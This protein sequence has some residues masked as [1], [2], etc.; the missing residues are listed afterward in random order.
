MRDRLEI[1]LRRNGS[2][3][4]PFSALKRNQFASGY[5]FT[6]NEDTVDI[7]RRY[8]TDE[9]LVEAHTSL[10]EV[11]NQLLSLF[12][13]YLGY[14][15]HQDLSDCLYKEPD[16]PGVLRIMRYLDS[17]P[18]GASNGELLPDHTDIGLI[19]LMPHSSAETL[20]ILSKDFDWIDVEKGQSSDTLVAIVGEQLAY[21][22]NY[23]LRAVRHRVMPSS[24]LNTTRYSMPFL[25][26]APA[27][28]QIIQNGTDKMRIA[29]HVLNHIFEMPKPIQRRMKRAKHLYRSYLALSSGFEVSTNLVS[30]SIALPLIDLSK[31][32]RWPIFFF[33]DHS[34]PSL[35]ELE[36]FRTHLSSCGPISSARSLASSLNGP[37][38]FIRIEER[39]WQVDDW[40]ESVLAFEGRSKGRNWIFFLIPLHLASTPNHA[41]EIAPVASF[42][43]LAYSV[44]S[45][46]VIT[47]RQPLEAVFDLNQYRLY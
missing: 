21:L 19:T 5:D 34:T 41:A 26:R 2:Q 16:T 15:A 27:D 46:I 18:E 44:R 12:C 29:K 1:R 43:D 38:A 14:S 30:V 8:Y 24:H 36:A 6:V 11:G 37:S 42:T 33:Y 17:P 35:T 9:N 25:M 39:G 7:I 32:F 40:P 23:K 22:S 3:K 20:Q 28:F 31:E 45:S 47:G 10:E 4:I 13:D